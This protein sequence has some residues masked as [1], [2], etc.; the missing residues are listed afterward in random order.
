MGSSENKKKI[1]IGD[2]FQISL[3]INSLLN[4]CDEGWKFDIKNEKLF[5]KIKK[6]TNNYV[7]STIGN[8]TAGKN[9][10]FKKLITKK[11][12]PNNN[13][14]IINTEIDNFFQGNS[15]GIKLFLPL[16]LESNIYYINT[17]SLN[18]PVLNEEIENEINENEIELNQKLKEVKKKKKFTNFFII[19]FSIFISNMILLIINEMTLETQQ[20]IDDVKMLINIINKESEKIITLIIVH[21]LKFYDKKNDVENYI[22]KIIENSY[23]NIEN[24]NQTNKNNIFFE[25]DIFKYKAIHI[26]IA[27]ENT[28]AG[29]YYNDSAISFI[30]SLDT[31]NIEKFNF[32]DS[33]KMFIKIMSFKIFN[34]KI[35]RKNVK[36]KTLSKDNNQKN[37]KFF[38]N[39][40]FKLN[41]YLFNKFD[42]IDN[43][44][45]DLIPKHEHYF[46]EENGYLN[47]IL[48][49]SGECK[50]INY[51][52]LNL[53]EPNFSYLIELE[54]EKKI[55]KSKSVEF[56]NNYLN[57]GK[58]KF[59]IKIE[60]TEFE[61]T[62]KMDIYK[63][64][65]IITC[66]FK[67]KYY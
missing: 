11:L 35:C 65:G 66:K 18:S 33:L 44:K 25:K 5:Q 15:E 50:I 51:K 57:E 10:F 23:F 17:L 37:K 2:F 38:V 29:N 6:K 27:K 30:N 28:Q 24:I 31:N 13:N 40:E 54:G 53:N 58:F 4:L 21:N 48:H 55:I 14:N 59:D 46:D 61:I 56:L 12:I 34:K 52:I 62:S 60:K 63:K 49:C 26:I 22:N 43:L 9:F 47:I 3:K 7:I 8:K 32:F 36:I 1:E 19:R 39:K 16:Y 64:D 42:K 45:L 20:L 41:K 67:L